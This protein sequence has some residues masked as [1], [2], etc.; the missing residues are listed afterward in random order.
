MYRRAQLKPHQKAIIDSRAQFTIAHGGVGTFKTSAGI[1][2]VITHCMK[3]PGQVFI[4]AG[5]TLQQVYDVIIAEWRNQVPDELY[6]LKQSGKEGDY[7]HFKPA[8]L[9]PSKLLIRYAD[10]PRAKELLRGSN[11]TGYYI[12]QAE[13]LKDEGYFDVLNERVRLWGPQI[14]DPT[15]I[16]EHKFGPYDRHARQAY[17]RN[18]GKPTPHPAYMMAV[19]ENPGSPAHFIRQ[20]YLNAQSGHFLGKGTCV[21][22]GVEEQWACYDWG[23]WI[24]EVHVI[25]TPFTSMYSQMTLDNW[26]DTRPDHEYKRMVLGIH[27]NAEGTVYPHWEEVKQEIKPE[28]VRRMII[29]IDPGTSVDVSKDEGNLAITMIAE[30]DGIPDVRYAVID[31]RA[32]RY[33]NTENLMT[34]I[35]GMVERWGGQ[36]RLLGIVMDWGGGSG[37]VFKTE[38]R[39]AGY[40]VYKPGPDDAKY[41]RVSYGVTVL[42]GALMAGHLKIGNCPKVK[43]DL[44]LYMNGANG[45]PDKKLYDSHL[46][47]AL[48]YG[49]QRANRYFGWGAPPELE[50]PRDDY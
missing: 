33:T 27:C 15:T 42:H 21:K 40:V 39:K 44:G 38:F 31:E 3:W 37:E 34:I 18:G 8:G 1:I 45:E 28:N 25:T 19:D 17:I 50:K 48:R 12:T 22:S 13:S 32:V 41:R 6:T 43:R 5:Q 47:D 35:S 29:G 20:R 30:I 46:L 36:H 9:K 49:W 26:R 14:I 2:R 7:I 10:H 23:Q 24:R 16:V 4:L 11:I